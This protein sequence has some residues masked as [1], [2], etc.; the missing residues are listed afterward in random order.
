MF[1]WP[2]LLT[3]PSEAPG[4]LR[5]AARLS[6]RPLLCRA[7]SD[8]LWRRS[9]PD[10][11]QFCRSLAQGYTV[12]SR[13]P[14][15]ARALAVNALTHRD[16]AA[17]WVLR[18]RAELA[19]GDVASAHESFERARALE[20]ASVDGVVVL[21]DRAVAAAITGQSDLAKR[22]FQTLGQRLSLLPPER[23]GRARVEAAM[24]LAST[25][26]SEARAYLT[27]AGADVEYRAEL[28]WGALTLALLG[29]PPGRD[30]AELDL[31]AL[32]Q[33]LS[34]KPSS[35][36]SP[37]L[38]AADALALVALA[39]TVA[40]SPEAPKLWA[41]YLSEAPQGTFREQALGVVEGRKLR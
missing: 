31:E 10:V 41:Q 34:L 37:R 36:T 3:W 21:H 28:P 24:A 2:L 22:L 16:F 14:G 6:A 15:R 4:E 17:A 7:A 35:S 20:A 23:R 30:L 38:P 18:A 33:E 19:L 25:H 11:A 8:D 13:D 9:R 26:V 27:Q 1:A 40:A 39:H 32:G 5:T 29:A 12:L